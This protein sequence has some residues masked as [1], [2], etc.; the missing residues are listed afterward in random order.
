MIYSD[1]KAVIRSMLRNKIP[2]LISILGLGIGLGCIIILLALIIHEKSFDTSIPGHRNVYRVVFGTEGQTYYA[3]AENMAKEF[4]EVK[5][6]FRYYQP[7]SVQ[8]KTPANEMV[9]EQNFGFADSSIFGII[10]IKFVSGTFAKSLAEVA[11]SDKAAM[12]YFGNLS[13]IGEVI[14][15]RF[16][17][18]FLNLSVSG[19]Y[20]SF[21]ANSTLN[22]SFLTDIRLSE[23]M[24]RQF[25][26]TLGEYAFT[27]NR[28]P[29]WS[30]PDFLS[31][32]VLDKSA[33]PGDLSVKMEKYREF[34]PNE[35]KDSLSFKL[36][37]VSEIYL[38]SGEITG[39][40]YLRR[41]N[42]EELKYYEIVS[43]LI[44]LISVANYVLLAR[45]GVSDRMHE[46]GTRKVFGA[47]H[48]QVRRLILLESGIIVLLG[49]LPA[50]FVIDTGLSFVNSTLNKT[51]TSQVF[52][53]PVLWILLVAVV[54]L[55]G[56][57]AGWIIG[58]NYSKIPA[59]K[60]I[61]GKLNSHS[62]SQKWN[63]SFLVLHFTIYIMLVSGVIAVSKQLN[64]S[65]TSYT[66]INVD[67]ILVADLNSDELK[68][69]F[70]TLC[71]EMEKI[72]GVVST[73][74][75]SYI[76]PLNFSL[77][78]NLAVA[79]GEKVRFDGLIMGEG[80]TELLGIEVIEGSS[81]GPF[82]PGTPEI[83]INESAAKKQN[84]K[85][86]DNLLVF[87]VRGIVRDFHAHSLHD[88]IQPMVIIPQNP[89][90]MSIM[91]IKTDGANDENIIKKLKE[92]YAQISPAEV[93]EVNHLSDQIDNFYVREKNQFRIIGAFSLLAMVL[94]AMGLFGISLI[95]IS[96]RRQEIG[97]RKVNGAS[98]VEVLFMLNTDFIKWV[99]IAI[100]ISVPA[101]IWLMSQWMKRFAYRT[102]LSWWIFA[103][104][105]CSAIIIAILTV[106]WQSWRAAVK[107]PVEALRYE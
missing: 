1:L 39:S 60:L 80:M 51:L 31:Y 86:G 5:D 68:N 42:P 97:I 102:E 35:R 107:N 71:D 6:F 29:G 18:G 56:F 47:S 62:R 89:F 64:Y 23:K 54:L 32:V 4:P 26:R 17:D 85:A 53:S 78:V 91:A 43:V 101:S 82:K 76:P 49:L 33:D 48:G 10:G 7:Y 37:P 93:F 46:F 79:G 75:G 3:L 16:P 94:A 11:V 69:S 105:G 25:Q 12:K 24:L 20:R 41:G 98:V 95:S 50:S 61:S 34:I 63:Y 55:T 14:P 92:L 2:S 58:L 84:V 88:L 28:S 19:V 100:V 81:F 96:R 21:P 38:R 59:L 30:S 40:L 99:M 13:P 52:L 57:L 15:V 77:P 87:K 67:N 103:I 27:D 65:M 83:L 8:L 104:A 36:Q 106:S 45:A 72:P 90:K 66:G 44:L 70:P 73:A 74:G 9:S 22:P